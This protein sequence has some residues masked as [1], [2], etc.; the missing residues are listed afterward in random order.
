[1]PTS[2]GGRA[3]LESKRGESARCQSQR[4]SR[5]SG[6][7]AGAEV[8]FPQETYGHPTLLTSCSCSCRSSWCR[9]RPLERQRFRMA[10]ALCHLCLGE[11]VCEESLPKQ[12]SILSG[13]NH[14]NSLMSWYE[15]PSTGI[16][17]SQ[18]TVMDPFPG[19]TNA[20]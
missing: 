5:K 6:R 10:L 20:A 9:L 7:S 18:Q 12:L 19:F 8:R 2:T 4:R 17:S 16:T 13:E 14:A 11:C 15:V 3:E 1:M